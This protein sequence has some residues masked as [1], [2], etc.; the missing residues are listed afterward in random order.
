MTQRNIVLL[1]LDTVRKD[2]FDE[3]A[4]QIRNRASLSFERAYAPSSWT[5]PSHAS[6]FTGVLPHEHGVHAHNTNFGAINPADTFFSDFETTKIGVSAN[7]FLSPQFGFDAFFDEFESLHGNEE[8]LTGGIDTAAFMNKTEASGLKKYVEYVKT[9]RAESALFESI[10]NAAYMK[11]NNA[12]L[13]QPLP[14]IGDYGARTV[15]KRGRKLVADTD[16]FFLFMNLVDAH[17]PHEVLRVYDTQVPSNWTSRVHSVWEINNAGPKNFPE[18]LSKFEE[19]YGHAVAY[20]DRQVEYF[21]DDILAQSDSETT[22][23]VTSDHGEELGRENERT[24]GHKIPSPAITHVP[25][26]VINPPASWEGGYVKELVSLLDISQLVDCILAGR[27]PRL[28][29]DRVPVERLGDVKP[30][31]ERMEFWN[32]AIRFVYEGDRAYEWDTMGAKNR[33]AV[34]PSEGRLV[35]EDISLP[36]RCTE[37]FDVDL[38]VVKARISETNQDL[39]AE[40]D[41]QTKNRL[42]DLGYM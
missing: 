12:V 2:V 24:I 33:Y 21:I 32:R 8:L 18:Y 17:A 5:V 30:P 3:R 41:E 35:A 39:A 16:S 20:L 15:L 42:E 7:S 27:Q 9:A 37:E 11:S 10:V 6:M 1:V 25:L 34:G 40:V 36:D 26:E 28:E 38:E 13:H 4:T 29:R 22:I 19:L 14:R 23:I 31:E